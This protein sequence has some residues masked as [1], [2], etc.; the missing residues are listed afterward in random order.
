MTKVDEIRKYINNLGI[1]ELEEIEK[2]TVFAYY[3]NGRGRVWITKTKS[4]DPRV[5]INIETPETKSIET[6]AMCCLSGYKSA[7]E[8]G[9]FQYPSFK[10]RTKKDIEIANPLIHRVCMEE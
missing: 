2:K 6:T 9:T 4:N 8:N 5:W 7:Q 3:K 10:A 1:P